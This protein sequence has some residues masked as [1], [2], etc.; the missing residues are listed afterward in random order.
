MAD[1]K[2]SPTPHTPPPLRRRGILAVLPA[3]AVTPTTTTAIGAG[4]VDADLL[5]LF[6]MWERN[7]AEYE[8]LA[9]A[10]DAVEGDTV[11]EVRLLLAFDGNAA[12][13]H[14]LHER[15]ASIP[16]RTWA[17]IQAKATIARRY[18]LATVGEIERSLLRDLVRG[19]D[20]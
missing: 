7:F 12:D 8:R 14:L 9:D 18:G 11:E 6:G 1:V 3:I 19:I 2:L 4:G 10:M 13:S 16:A 5:R 15:I 20:A 17:G